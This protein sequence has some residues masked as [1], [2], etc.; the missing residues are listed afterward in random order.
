MNGQGQV[1]GGYK[2][3]REEVASMEYKG[4]LAAT[5]PAQP[6]LTS[7]VYGREGNGR[8]VE[9]FDL[10]GREHSGFHILQCDLEARSRICLA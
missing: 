10:Q 2:R 5:R 8:Q 4:R 1:D 6:G 9:S 7:D 3:A